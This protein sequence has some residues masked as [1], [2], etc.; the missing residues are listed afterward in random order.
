MSQVSDSPA[1]AVA[2]GSL[3]RALVR[4]GLVALAFLLGCFPMGDFD[5]WWHLRTGELIPERG[6]PTTDWFSFTTFDEPWIDAQWGFQVAAAWVHGKF[7]IVGLNLTKALIGAL[8]VAVATGAYRPRWPILPQALVWIP[9]LL[10]VSSRFYPRPEIVTLLFTAIFLFVLFHAEDAP[11]LLWLLPPVQ[12]IW[13]NVHGLFVFGPVLVAL[14]F[15]EA[16]LR[17]GRLGGVFRHLMPVTVLV[18]TA[19]LASPYLFGNLELANQLWAKMSPAAGSEI[20]RDNIT[21]LADFATFWREGGGYNV[22]AWLYLGLAALSV[23]SIF[24]A[25]RAILLDRRV[26]RPL[27]LLAFGYLAWRAIRNGNHFGLVAGTIV[28]WNLGGLAW[29]Q[30][31][32]GAQGIALALGIVG[33]ALYGVGSGRWYLFAGEGR[34]IGL[35]EQPRHYGR[36]G[37]RVAGHEGMPDRA[38][39]FHLGHAS[40]YIHANGPER[41]VF[42]DARLELH[43][44]RRFREYLALRDSLSAGVGGA[45]VG[46]AGGGDDYQSLLD[47]EQIGAVIADGRE[48]V[49]I[50]AT[51]LTDPRW[52]AVHYDEVLAVFVRRHERL[53]DGVE[54]VE[55]RSLL[56]ADGDPAVVDMPEPT[57]PPTW[58]WSVPESI[59][60]GAVDDEAGAALRLAVALGGM[61]APSLPRAAAAWLAAQR[62]LAAVR[63]RPWE[64][65]PY[66][67]L[68]I[69][70]LLARR[71]LDPT[72]GRAKPTESWN[73]ARDA[74]GATAAHALTV[75]L[76]VDPDDFSALY[77]LGEYYWEIG[78]EDLSVTLWERLLVGQPR[79]AA[80]LEAWPTLRELTAARRA[81]V[82]EVHKSLAADARA[83]PSKLIE[84]GLVGE[85][86]KRI[87]ATPAPENPAPD[88]AMLWLYRIGR[89]RAAL[90]ALATPAGAKPD[91]GPLANAA[92][93]MAEGKFSGAKALFEAA[94]RDPNM[95]GNA[96]VGLS[97]LAL[98][99]GDRA[100]ILEQARQYH[101][102]N[103]GAST[104]AGAGGARVL[105]LIELVE[106]LAER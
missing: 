46:A 92:C 8:A 83:A 35:G 20:Y 9:A 88:E 28:S 43:S 96:R 19:T 17:M 64:A 40:T 45:T 48:S 16:V 71:A 94:A 2:R 49:A 31:V 18:L 14:Y 22:H 66:R 99:S 21:E 91:T 34:R 63:R 85:A 61:N 23:L 24:V 10:L 73:L 78:A 41:K 4:L 60:P 90:E 6:V 95:H 68:G 70:L 1:D 79:N 55:L 15:A 100:G 58:W 50:Q 51:L 47:Q 54:P 102:A 33:L 26:F 11:A 97:L 103:P 106:R 38:L 76:R 101:A 27:A 56:F 52:K 65:G 81:A 29:G 98:L 44:Q 87:R 104:G 25:W 30:R 42:M 93:L 13:V 32:R 67:D 53:P 5:I 39:I 37:I 3:G 57:P 74:L 84:R 12:V 72:G 89:P 86:L 36:A 82:D 69:S 62:S 59:L 7:G 75:A 80:Q 105:A 77:Y